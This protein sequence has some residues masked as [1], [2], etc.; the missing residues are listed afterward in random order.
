VLKY[1]WKVIVATHTERVK[2]V[3]WHFFLRFELLVSTFMPAK[4]SLDCHNNARTRANDHHFEI[5]TVNLIMK[6]RPKTSKQLALL[7]GLQGFF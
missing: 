1:F 6:M 2:P 3:S 7:L 4:L 5:P